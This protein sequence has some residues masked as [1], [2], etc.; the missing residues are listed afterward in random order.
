MNRRTTEHTMTR[1]RKYHG[2]AKPWRVVLVLAVLVVA[3]PAVLADEDPDKPLAA[4]PKPTTSTRPVPPAHTTHARPDR[5]SLTFSNV[6]VREALVRIAQYAGVDVLLAPGATGTISINL[7]ERTPD[8][9]IRMV[10][11]SAGLFVT[12]AQGAFVVGSANE[13]QRAVSEFGLTEIVPVQHAKPADAAAFLAKAA[14]T[15]K[16][17]ALANAVSMTGLLDDLRR[18]RETL[19]SYDVPVPPEPERQDT[20]L[21]AMEKTSPESA[22]AV[23]RQAFPGVTVARQDRVI[24]V[25][26]PASVLPTVEKAAKAI[27]VAAPVE[28]E[29]TE[30]AVVKLQYLHA[31]KV[32]ES[33]KVVFPDVKVAAGPEPNMP[34]MAFFYPMTTGAFGTT[35]A[36][37]T[38]GGAGGV[39]GGAAGVGGAGAG[40]GGAGVGGGAGGEGGVFPA[41]TRASSVVLVGKA[42]EVHQA[43]K[44]V[45]EMDVPQALVRI[46]AALVEV[47]DDAMK[48]LGVE[49]SWQD[50]NFSFAQRWNPAADQTK[51]LEGGVTTSTVNVSDFMATIKALATKKKANVLANPNITCVDNEDASIFIGELRR[52]RGSTVVSPGIGTV[53]GTETVPVGIALLVRPRIHPD[54]NITLKVHPVVST[55]L[56]VV[57]GLPQTASREADTT[58]RMRAGEELVIGGLFKTEDI[59]SESKVPIL[60]DLPIL[61]A[62]F[63]STNHT[64][65]RTEVVV[66]L[67]VYPVYPNPAPEKDFRNGVTPR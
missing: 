2:L 62:L 58:V 34:P 3:G 57:D 25:T 24:V 36:G 12:R 38:S 8:E 45:Q 51:G 6:D 30:V 61:G 14:P 16:V 21:I 40:V 31:K 48:D 53:Q 44:A 56:S 11:A 13:I 49:W 52:F 60:G 50:G 18:A 7:R 37:G 10:A 9:A 33:L 66:V 35:G 55:V 22:E 54:G 17:E 19:R 47:S 23:L 59:R 29:Q 4:R 27:D 20:L 41:F 39:A 15:V 28:V 67:R 64:K 46:D 26:G 42:S 32:E 65:N 43:V 1:Q 63:R 5:I